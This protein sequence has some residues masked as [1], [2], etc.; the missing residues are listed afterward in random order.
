MKEKVIVILIL[1]LCVCGLAG[2]AIYD[3]T[4]AAGNGLWPTPGNWSITGSAPGWT[5]PNEQWNNEYTNEDCDQINI[6]N[7]DAVTMSDYLSIDGMRDGSNIAVLTIDNGS[8]L[9][10]NNGMWIADDDNTQGRVDVL[11]GSFLDVA[12]DLKVGDD[13]G[14]IGTMNVID[15][16]V[17]VADD[18]VV[19]N[20]YGSTGYLYIANSTINVVDNF[21]MNDAS[22][23]GVSTS[24]V[25][26]DSGT[27]NVGGYCTFNDDIDGT[28]TVILNGGS[29]NVV[30]Y[31]NLSDNLDG[32]AY[33]TINAGEMI[34]G[35]SL[36]LGKDD[37]TNIGQVRI[38]MNGG[39]LQGEDIEFVITDTKIIFSDGWGK[40][41]VNSAAVSEAAM[42][43]FIDSGNID[44]SALYGHTISTD[45]GYTALMPV[46]GT[47]G[48]VAPSAGVGGV[49]IDAI[50]EWLSPEAYVQSGFTVYLGTD[51]N[52]QS[53]YWLDNNEIVSGDNVNEIDPAGD[54]EYNTTYYWR[55]DAL[56]PNTLGSG[57]I[58]HEGMLW[59][60]TTESDTPVILTHPVAQFVDEGADADFT[61]A[62]TT[63]A[64]TTNTF[65]WFVDPNAVQI[66]SD[67]SKYTI[68]SDD[69][70]STLTIHGA[71]GDDEGWYY[72]RVT[73]DDAIYVY[74][75][76]A[77]LALNKLL[78]YWPLDEGAGLVAGDVVGGNDGTLEAGVNW[79]T[80]ILGSAMETNVES[81][82]ILMSPDPAYLTPY[83]SMSCWAI[84]E[85]AGW[86]EWSGIVGH[87]YDTGSTEAGWG[88]YEDGTLGRVEFYASQGGSMVTL[89]V[90]DVPTGVWNHYVGTVSD[91][92][93]ALYLN[94]VLVDSTPFTG[95]VDYSET[96]GN[97]D[98]IPTI[99]TYVDD[100]END[101]FNGSVDEV[102]IYNY[103]VDAYT[104]AELYYEGSGEPICLDPP[105]YD[106]TD[107][108]VVDLADVA[109]VAALWAECGRHPSSYCP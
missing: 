29:W 2:A 80:G 49:P 58:V 105:A 100:D 70:T 43:G 86:D 38:Y 61:V 92:E 90:T 27:V 101:Y 65:E 35:G 83:M 47:A 17:D 57:F 4:G 63:L 78:G 7:G 94:G 89:N 88:L 104:V 79:V 108:C 74:S 77:L 81:A 21:Y 87:F 32:H 53:P 102:R 24:Y 10:A 42:Q 15:S 72:C 44:V 75:R 33:L 85:E 98:I 40:L 19:A 84:T 26:M 69:A 99:G 59:N 52:D 8:T 37:G 67:G 107:D 66:V 68:V 64:G 103:A 76:G 46:P 96:P 22:G 39:L 50:L 11:G 71:A 54:L 73:N 18:M 5:H 55:V 12:V 20:Y 14:S 6:L 30:E 31:L 62:A 25:E 34:S 93:I 3:W 45:S 91:T 41:K 36:R 28:A 60:F 97:W 9:N 109:A 23:A 48:I 16:R 106:L 82:G 95:G 56:E 51:P 13:Q 1:G